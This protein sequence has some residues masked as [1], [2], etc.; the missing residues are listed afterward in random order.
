MLSPRLT[1]L[2]VLPW[3]RFA[4]N[5]LFPTSRNKGNCTIRS[6]LS[7]LLFELQILSSLLCLLS[8][9]GNWSTGSSRG[10]EGWQPPQGLPCHFSPVA[11]GCWS[12]MSSVSS[13]PNEHIGLVTT[14]PPQFT[15]KS[16]RG[17]IHCGQPEPVRNCSAIP[18]E[19][20]LTI[21]SSL[22]A[23]KRSVPSAH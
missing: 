23:A 2:C 7:L 20:E 3:K 11:K 18:S 12:E 21:S 16:L 10:E 9:G 6:A 8:R 13:L 22:E 19:N 1:E 17:H 15:A 4:E 5:L 14:P